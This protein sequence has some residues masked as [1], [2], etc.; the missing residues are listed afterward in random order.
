[1]GKLQD[2]T[3]LSCG[4]FDPSKEDY[5]V[6]EPFTVDGST[7]WSDERNRKTGEL[8]V[9]DCSLIALKRRLGAVF[10]LALCPGAVI[11]GTAL[12]QEA[13]SQPPSFI[14]GGVAALPE[15]EGSDAFRVVPLVVSNFN[16]LGAR[17]EA[18]GIQGINVDVIPHPVWRAGPSLGAALP[19]DDNADDPRI[20]LLPEVSFSVEAGGF[21]GF[22]TA[23]G[24]LPEGRVSG[25]IAVRHDVAGGHQGLIVK[26][27]L[28]YFF[29]ATDRLRF[30]VGT[31]ATY[32]N[33]DFFD[34]FFTVTPEA[35]L[36]SGL[37]AFEADAGLKDVGVEANMILSFS[38]R[39]A[40]FVR[41]AYNRLLD[42]AADSPVVDVAGDA[43]QVF[44][45][46]GLFYSF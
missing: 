1:M 46:G 17:V 29:A 15:F 33:Q 37:A 9:M 19:R 4:M 16:L 45:G 38:P 28:D 43:N 20:Q 2:G 24:G 30:S 39:Y 31:N 23:V 32:A 18:E 10:A 5:S 13:R 34:S 11:P 7:G 44:I 36:A 35:S 12:A 25:E 40:V 41:G 14:V 3:R 21:V 26:A 6:G 22:E 8:V 42:D 27:D